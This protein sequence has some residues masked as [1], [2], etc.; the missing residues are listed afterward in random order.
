MSEKLCPCHSSLSY[1][2]CCRPYHLGE[3]PP[4]A[5]AQMRARYSAYALGLVDYI[6][7]TTH[8]SHPE[9]KDRPLAEWRLNIERFSKQTAFDG[10]K[11]LDFS[12]DEAKGTVTFTAI[13]SS[14]GDDLT[15]SEMSYFE[16]KGGR[17]LYK[18]GVPVR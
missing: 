16:K 11:I 12:E 3:L 15:F 6:V 5:L 2:E 18:S 9:C 1:K 7:K 14:N 13:L 10:L 4:T 8:P 17:W